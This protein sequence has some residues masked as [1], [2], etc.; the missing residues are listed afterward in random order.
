MPYNINTSTNIHP[1][2][3]PMSFELHPMPELNNTTFKIVF[4][5]HNAVN[6]FLPMTVQEVIAVLEEQVANLKAEYLTE[7]DTDSDEST[8]ANIAEQF[9]ASPL[10]QVVNNILNITG[11]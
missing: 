7:T 4:R 2:E 8:L 1:H 10:G 9:D 5:H 11:K 6:I 3:M